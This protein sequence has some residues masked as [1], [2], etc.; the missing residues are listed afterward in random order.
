M[1]LKRVD[2]FDHYATAEMWQKL[3]PWNAQTGNMDIFAGTSG[4]RYT[5][6]FRFNGA[7]VKGFITSLVAQSAFV[8]GFAL[9]IINYGGSSGFRV[10]FYDGATVQVYLHFSQDGYYR[11]YRGD[12]T[13]LLGPQAAAIS[14]SQWYFIEF[15]CTISDTAGAGTCAVK[16][17]GIT[18]LSNGGTID[19]KNSANAYGD[20]LVIC[21]PGNDQPATAYIDDLYICDGVDATATQG[22][23]NNNFLGDCGAYAILPNGAGNYNAQFTRVG[24][25]VDSDYKA[26]DEALTDSSTT[27]LSDAT[28]GDKS[29]WTYSDL[30]PTAGT[31]K[32]V[33]F[34][35]HIKKDDAGTRT[36][37]SFIR[38][39]DVDY[40]GATISITSSYTFLQDIWSINPATSNPFT[41][42]EINALEAGIEVVA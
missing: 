32:A 42:S 5:Q 39:V 12:G 11:V 19:T 30:A 41:I 25:G 36:Y 15:K 7:V 21:I 29:S 28:P 8:V 37:R 26:V 3:V 40:P 20:S 31:V 16:Q 17:D 1:T 35:Y 2:S 33:V 24:V 10:A 23:P 22:A 34:S 14:P 38:I 6:T 4:R 13:L 9:K 18:I 27:Y